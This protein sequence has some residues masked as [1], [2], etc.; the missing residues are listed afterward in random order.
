VKRTTIFILFLLLILPACVAAGNSSPEEMFKKTFP[1]KRLESISPTP[2]K[3]VY[4]VYTGNELFYYAPEA[5]VLIYGNLVSKEGTS[6]TRDSY[7]KKMATK[8]SQLPLDKALK[9]GKG[10]TKIVE[11]MDPNCHYCKLS[12]NYLSQRKDVTVYVF[13]YPLSP[14][15]EN[16]IKHIFC[17]ADQVK[18]YEEVMEGKFDDVN[19]LNICTDKKAE[20]ILRTHRNIA[21]QMGIMSTPFFYVKGQIVDGFEAPVFDNI[22][23]K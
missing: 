10:K 14:A 20:D 12:Y 21:A 19:K 23:K 5:E 18:M 16:K 22:L 8:M 17:A 6:I 2:V 13:F 1:N 9:V 4:E 7:L 3:G 15:S 11:F